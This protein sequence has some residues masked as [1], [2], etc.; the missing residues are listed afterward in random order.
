MTTFT[1]QTAGRDLDGIEPPNGTDAGEWQ[2]EGYRIIYGTAYGVAGRADIRVQ[3]TA[4]QLGDGTI[5][6]GSVI[7]GPCVHVDGISGEPLSVAQARRLGAAIMAAADELAALRPDPADPLDGV[8]M[9]QL[10]DHIAR[11]VSGPGALRAAIASADPAVLT[12]EDRAA[13]L[14]LLRTTYDAAG[15]E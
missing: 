4:L 7:E 15:I 6:D 8:S 13:L 14:D 10:L 1:N 12:R 2:P 9:V 11:R 3:P 5:D